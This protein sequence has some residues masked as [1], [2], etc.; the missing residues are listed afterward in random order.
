[1]GCCMSGG[2]RNSNDTGGTTITNTDPSA[3]G[4]IPYWSSPG[5]A[6]PGTKGNNDTGGPYAGMSKSAM[7]NFVPVNTGGKC[8]GELGALSAAHES[9]ND[10]G[11]V[12]ADA[13]GGTD[14]GTYQLNTNGAV[15]NFMKY[16][17]VNDPTT[18]NNLLSSGSIGSS[19]FGAAWKNEAAT[20]SNFADLQGCFMKQ[21]Y[22]DTVVKNMKSR[23][24]V[25]I[26]SYPMAVK[27]GIF[28]TAVQFGQNSNIFDKT[29]SNLPDN[30]TPED[31]INKLTDTKLSKT[32]SG[33][34]AYFTKVSSSAQ[35]NIAK[36]FQSERN[37]MLK[38]VSS[39][40]VES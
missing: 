38:S 6:S 23:Y 31:V 25:D 22:Y 20:N 3:D 37:Y 33:G 11:I 40:P 14:Y 1:M 28:G 7:D 9:G 17:S 27:Q 16:L 13:A 24:G 30:A 35:I 26:D 39:S 2:K 10:P 18:Y 29:F 36:R 15:Q 5:M 21:C 34:L 32:P 19:G 4:T 8:D 12:N